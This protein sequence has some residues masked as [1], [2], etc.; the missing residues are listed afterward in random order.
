MV[1]YY[2][3]LAKLRHTYSLLRLGKGEE[4]I[5]RV[6]FHNTGSDQIPGLIIMSI[7]NGIQV[8]DVSTNNIDGLVVAI[9]ASPNTINFTLPV[10]GLELSPVYQS[11]LAQGVSI[12][13]RELTLPAWTPA[14]LVLPR[15][16]VRG[17]GIP[18]N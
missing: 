11:D 7:D 6:K 2:K 12:E 13:E 5:K 15:Q 1:S 16:S 3:D 18:I 8:D 14:V 10:E 17:E 4:V 9:N